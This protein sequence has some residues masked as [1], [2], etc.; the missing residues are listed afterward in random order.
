MAAFQAVIPRTTAL[1]VVSLTIIRVRHGK[2]L[3]RRDITE[4][5]SNSHFQPLVVVCHLAHVDH[6]RGHLLD[7]L[8]VL[9]VLYCLP[10]DLDFLHCFHPFVEIDVLAALVGKIGPVNCQTVQHMERV[11]KVANAM[12]PINIKRSWQ[13]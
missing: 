11:G 1:R 6:H 8:V 3:N 12:R 4:K 7:V 10:S 9:L 5:E 2:L 13:G